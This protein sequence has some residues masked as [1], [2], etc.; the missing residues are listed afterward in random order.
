MILFMAF[1]HLQQLTSQSGKVKKTET[2][3][4]SRKVSFGTQ[5]SSKEK[6]SGSGRIVKRMKCFCCGGEH[7]LTECKEFLLM[8]PSNMF[9]FVKEK[10]ICFNCLNG[11]THLSRSCFMNAA[12]LHLHLPLPVITRMRVVQQ[13]LQDLQRLLCRL[14]LSW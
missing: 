6:Q 4:S 9:K 11:S 14:C 13:L 8:S 2:S 1:N 7:P 5:G 10:F 12:H 3:G